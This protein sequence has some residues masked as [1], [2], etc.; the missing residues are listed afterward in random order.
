MERVV[1]EPKHS[2]TEVNLSASADSGDLLRKINWAPLHG[3]AHNESFYGKSFDPEEEHTLTIMIDVPYNR[4]AN[5]RGVKDPKTGR[6]RVVRE[7]DGKKILLNNLSDTVVKSARAVCRKI[8]NYHTHPEATEPV[9]KGI[10]IVYMNQNNSYGGNSYDTFVADDLYDPTDPEFPTDCKQIALK[11]LELI[12]YT[13]MIY[14]KSSVMQLANVKKMAYKDG[15]I[16]A[17]IRMI[18]YDNNVHNSTPDYREAHKQWTKARV[19]YVINLSQID[20]FE[21]S[22]LKSDQDLHDTYTVSYRDHD[23][24]GKSRGYPHNIGNPADML[25]YGDKYCLQ[26]D[27]P[28]LVDLINADI[29]EFKRRIKTE[30]FDPDEYYY[31]KVVDPIEQGVDMGGLVE[32]LYDKDPAKQN[33]LEAEDEDLE[34]EDSEDEDEIVVRPKKKKKGGMAAGAI[35]PGVGNRNLT[36]EEFMDL[37]LQAIA[38]AEAKEDQKVQVEPKGGPTNDPVVNPDPSVEEADVEAEI[39]PTFSLEADKIMREIYRYTEMLVDIIEKMV[40]GKPEKAQ[41]SMVKHY[42]ELF[43]INQVRDHIEARISGRHGTLLSFL[44]REARTRN[45]VR[46]DDFEEDVAKHIHH[47]L[48]GGAGDTY[49]TMV[50]NSKGTSD[51][52]VVNAIRP[53]AEIYYGFRTYKRAGFYSGLAGPPD[54]PGKT[55]PILPSDSSKPRAM[56]WLR[57]IYG[58]IYGSLT[59][60]QVRALNFVDVLKLDI[61]SF[62]DCKDTENVDAQKMAETEYSVLQISSKMI[63]TIMANSTDGSYYSLCSDALMEYEAK[64]RKYWERSP[65][66]KDHEKRF[67]SIYAL[68]DKQ[69]KRETLRIIRLHKSL[70]QFLNKLTSPAT[71]FKNFDSKSATKFY[72]ILAINIIKLNKKLIKY[73]GRRK[74]QQFRLKS[75]SMAAIYSELSKYFDRVKIHHFTQGFEAREPD[76]YCY[77]TMEST[78]ETGGYTFYPHKSRQNEYCYPSYVVSPEVH[79]MWVKEKS[80]HSVKCPVCCANL[81]VN[82]LIRVAP[83]DERDEESIESNDNEKEIERDVKTININIK[84][85]HPESAFSLKKMTKLKFDFSRSEKVRFDGHLIFGHSS[86][87]AFVNPD[88]KEATAE[89]KSKVPEFLNRISFENIVV[90]GGMCRSILL[91]QPIQDVDIFFVGLDENGVRQR[92]FT[93]INDVIRANLKL[94]K[95]MRFILMYKPTYHVVELLCVKRRIDVE[96]EEGEEDI[97]EE[98]DSDDDERIFETP[99]IDISNTSLRM[100]R[101]EEDDNTDQDMDRDEEDDNTDQDPKK[102]FCNH[103]I[104]HKVQIILRIQDSI[105]GVFENFDMYPSC[106]AYNGK[107]VLFN[108]HSYN[109]YKY[110][111]NLVDPMKCRHNRYNYRAL[112]YYKYGFAIG[113]DKDRIPD[114]ILQQLERVPKSYKIDRCKFETKYRGK[115]LDEIGFIPV[116]EFKILKRDEET[117]EDLNGEEIV[118]AEPLYKAYDLDTNV[119]HLYDYIAEEGIKYCFLTGPIT[120]TT[121]ISDVMTPNSIEFLTSTRDINYDWYDPKRQEIRT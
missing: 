93:L 90:A 79:D 106:V 76:Y 6:T 104:I 20:R 2:D 69:N 46:M 52:C 89:F 51:I 84:S 65:E 59:D 109:A 82:R 11:E 33:P 117:N 74:K 29:A 49:V 4:K 7:K 112:K 119:E 55:F 56:K 91:R 12:G 57:I 9:K 68:V 26:S 70:V 62:L 19:Q 97:E 10:R 28:K 96:E 86:G 50:D 23:M 99:N 81:D 53:D 8:Y 71:V 13:Y 66:S 118:Y 25:F 121:E 73:D 3:T 41:E 110:M 27:Y 108:Q 85:F 100:D 61:S 42:T 14:G 39:E 35:L 15:K 63:R 54:N 36:E 80:K 94:D 115:A 5:E 1:K 116:S 103:E 43:S 38:E 31:Q 37:A 64:C 32:L 44:E 24:Y 113:I 114:Q 40:R 75:T 45:A 101:D 102:R 107:K 95:Q 47:G 83:Q 105:K 67:D 60:Q 111:V 17:I 120:A 22:H 98:D 88:G 78:E 77:Y 87:E 72:D 16:R 30:S 92:L 18:Y 58:Q 34:D 48:N 21:L